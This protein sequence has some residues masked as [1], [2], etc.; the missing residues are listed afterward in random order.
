MASEKQSWSRLGESMEAVVAQVDGDRITKLSPDESQAMGR[1]GLSPVTAASA[2]A[3]HDPRRLKRPKRRTASGWEEVE[4]ETAIREI[5]GQ[6]KAI[7]KQSGVRALG[8]YAGAPVGTN[9]RGLARTMSFALGLGTPN[10]YSPLSAMGGPLLR[11]S[12]LVVGHPVAWQT[13]V[14]RAHFVVLLGANQDAQGWG[15]LQTGRNLAADLAFSRKTKG[16]K[17]V[18]V[19][20][21][22]TPTT[23]GADQHLAIRPGTELYFM[24]AV[25]DQVLKSGWHEKQYVDDWCAGLPKLVDAVAPWTTERAAHICGIT[26]EEIA[27]VALK[28]TRAAMAC[29]HRSPQ[30][31]QSEHGTLTA[32]SILALQAI[33][34]N[35]M[36]PGG[37]YD[38]KGVL[39][40]HGVVSQLPTEKA[41]RT[42]SGDFPVLLLQA[43]GA[44]LSDDILK[45][46]EGQLRALIAVH[47]NPAKEQPGGARLHEALGKL[48][49]LVCLDVADNE[50]TAL[51]HWV[52]P[53]SH[54]WE[55]EDL[56]LHDASILPHRLA[57]YTPALVP[58]PGEARD[59]SD[60]LADLFKAV[61][62]SL[63]QG[64]HGAHL[65]ALGTYLSTAD[66][67]AWE[68]RLFDYSGKVSLTELKEKGWWW[69]GEVDRATWR[70]TT[71]SEKIE[72]VPDALAPF[73]A[74][75]GDPRLAPSMDSW[76]IASAARD[77][78]LR[79]FDRPNSDDPGVT[80]HPS[81][82]FAE[83]SRV[84]IVTEA[85]R[86]EATVHLDD[87]LR[88]DTVDLP[89]GY[90][91]DVMQIIPSDRLDPFTGT[92]A[93]S[94]LSC[95]VEK[96]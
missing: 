53:S 96:A 5:A 89:A 44:V 9:S 27:G 59:E 25:L 42:R 33:T 63:R 38:H 90:A 73:L 24:L 31:L 13:D 7:R 16:T 6:L 78:A 30:A 60:I 47:G 46:G 77:E 82:G 23:T 41:P 34:A 19:D 1:H 75:L 92:P 45:P 37:L 66:L 4:W 69:G 32:W 71:P 56:H 84:R 57:A 55:R 36:R 70:V 79:A 51:A 20:P 15:P 17:V 85:G 50:T 35:L 74:S 2:G 80:L 11:A 52:L 65:R 48:D 64:V 83:G 72:L 68:S 76:L 54:C 18:A 3:N 43:P 95:R 29:V 14:G 67:S 8:V 88:P 28:Y 58:A 26:A 22:R 81:R 86:V 94:G 12:E 21:R 62:P 87:G 10:L 93:M 40:I 61:G 39:D 91:A 49:L